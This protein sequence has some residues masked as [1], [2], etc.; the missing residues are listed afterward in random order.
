MK[1]GEEMRGKRGAKRLDDVC[2]GRDL[3]SR[4]SS[5]GARRPLLGITLCWGARLL[6]GAP[7]SHPAEAAPPPTPHIII[8]I[9]IRPADPHQ[10]DET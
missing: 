7:W 2:P 4:C 8:I 1:R 3:I 10:V 5:R 6:K 9:I